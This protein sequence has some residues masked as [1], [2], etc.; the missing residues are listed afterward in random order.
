MFFE[1]RFEIS[2]LKTTAVLNFLP[3]I[4]G[5]VFIIMNTCNIMKRSPLENALSQ[6]N[7]KVLN[8]RFDFLNQFFVDFLIFVLPRFRK[9]VTMFAYK[10]FFWS[11]VTLTLFEDYNDCILA[12]VMMIH[13]LMIANCFMTENTF[14][15]LTAFYKKRFEDQTSIKISLLLI[16]S[17]RR[18]NCDQIIEL[19]QAVDDTKKF[20][21]NRSR[22]T[23]LY[24]IGKG[25]FG[26][27]FKGILS[28]ESNEANLSQEI[29]IKMI[30]VEKTQG[31]SDFEFLLVSDKMQKSL[32]EEAMRMIRISAE[33]V[34][35]LKGFCVKDEPYLLLMEFM[36]FGDLHS[37][38]T[39]NKK[40]SQQTLNFGYSPRPEK[41][42]ETIKYEIRPTQ[43]M[44][45]EIAD[46]M[47]YLEHLKLVHRDLAARNCMVSN[48]FTIK[49]GDFGLTRF[50]DS[51]NYYKAQTVCEKPIRW[52]APES[53][54]LMN[55]FSSKSDVFSYGIVLWELVTQGAL[56]YPVS[57]I[58]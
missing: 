3:Y 4:F 14:T 10:A 37:F 47:L 54:A 24:L 19:V 57:K 35:Q 51:S 46:G 40:V 48:D 2:S 1:E 9:L 33:H 53:I 49:V 34:V 28:P 15:I 45:L 42:V 39:K 30:K 16:L 8:E 44:A 25:H 58:R 31:M 11:Y 50:I 36:K 41:V 22:V 32:A 20:E 29:A 26:E 18:K 17:F 6:A 56:P 43:H 38:L 7:F 52:M 27:V 55:K 13:P 21:I 23:Q 5:V 12:F